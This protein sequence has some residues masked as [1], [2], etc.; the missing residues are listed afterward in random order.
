MAGDTSNDRFNGAKK[1]LDYGFANY[2]F[3]EIEADLENKKD[4]PIK[5]GVYK[6]VGIEADG[7]L[8]LLLPKSESKTISQ[9]LTFK[10][11]VTAPISK[12]DIVGN[13]EIYVGDKSVGSIKIIA[14]ASVERLN[15]WIIFKWLASSLLIL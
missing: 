11:D 9:K 2:S 13:A 5:K 14:N 6:K 15:L 4:I 1:L 8:K 12:G 7:K 3:F 10:K